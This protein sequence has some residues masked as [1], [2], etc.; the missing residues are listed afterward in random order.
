MTS[1]NQD[2]SEPKAS[3]RKRSLQ[4]GGWNLIATVFTYAL[5]LF[6]N[7]IMTRLVLPEA[8]GMLAMA[9]VVLTALDM[10][11]DIGINRSVVREKDGSEIHFLRVAWVVKL[12]RSCFIA[13][14]VLI[15]AF[16]LWVVGPHYAPIDSVYGRPEMPG[17]L[18]L[19][20]LS[21]VLSGLS[22][23]A[24]ELA[25]RNMDYKRLT[26][27]Q[28]AS[29]II[30]TLAMVLFAQ[31]NP[32]AWA[33]MAGMLTANFLRCIFSH[34]LLSGPKMRFEWNREI[35]DR[36]WSFGRWI[37]AS[38]GLG[39]IVNNADK[40]ILGGLLGSTTFGILVIAQIWVEAGKQ[41]I[42][43]LSN[44]VGFPAIAEVY[45]ERPSDVSRLYRKFQTVIDGICLLGFAAFLF[46]GPFLIRV[47]YTETYHIAGAYLQIMS[48][49][50]LV[51]RFNSLSGLLLNTGQSKSFLI[52]KVIEAGAMCCGVPLGFFLM[53]VE[54]AIL[55]AALSRIASV[56]YILFR[57]KEILGSTQTLFD[58]F[59]AIGTL[60]LA[61]VL[62][63]VV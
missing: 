19:V 24:I 30:S 59:W 60:I 17:L 28:I 21:P 45:R 4:A 54:G 38:S 16:F 50:F 47:L 25:D 39:F 13:I 29:Q 6:S 56:P 14:L 1:T 20:A 8:F 7:L 35:S 37:L 15:A 49:A 11:T 31:F 3:L 63:M 51:E 27:F 40:L 10:M 52:A 33:L 48:V 44:R 42:S 46:G 53:G 26:Y 62:V 5:R 2:I 41:F 34:T 9:V 61:F 22:S 36:L 55:G 58:G 23:T 12:V 32:T 43:Q 18:A 57:T